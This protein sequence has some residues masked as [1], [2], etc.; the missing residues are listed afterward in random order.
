MNT[1][2]K[3]VKDSLFFLLR[4]KTENLPIKV[5]CFSMKNNGSAR[6]QIGFVMIPIRNIPLTLGNNTER[7]CC[8]GISNYFF[9]L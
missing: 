3:H 9:N 6:E 5:E 2:V 1:T 4:M 8:L 7:V